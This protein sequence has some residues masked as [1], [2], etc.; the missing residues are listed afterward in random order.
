MKNIVK[1][2]SDALCWV[3]GWGVLAS[4]LV[5]GMTFFGY[6]AAI[7]IG[8]D[9]AAEICRFISKDLMP[10]IIKTSSVLMVLGI[11]VMY[12]N[13]EVAMTTGKKKK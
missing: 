4:V 6:V 8:G 9:I 2:L 3:F 13:G 7:C 1:K 10:V 12:L 5:G 11:L